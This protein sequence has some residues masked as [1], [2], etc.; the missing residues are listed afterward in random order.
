MHASV[1][2]CAYTFVYVHVGE[3][4]WIEVTQRVSLTLGDSDVGVFNKKQLTQRTSHHSGASSREVDQQV[5]KILRG[6]EVGL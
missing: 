4:I 2:K 3:S 5:R 1:C 6:G